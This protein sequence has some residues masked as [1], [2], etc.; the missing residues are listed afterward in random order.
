MSVRFSD[1]ARLCEELRATNSK[2]EKS[3]LLADF[4]KGLDDA[5]LTQACLF[6][7]GKA[8]PETDPRTLKVST[9]TLRKVRG[10]A[11]RHG[12]ALTVADVAE[13]FQELATTTGKGSRKRVDEL[14]NELF[15]QADELERTYLLKII[16]GE[17]QIG[18][19]EGVLLQGIA[20]GAGV[21]LEE[22][23][24]A[25]MFLGHAGEVA[26]LALRA[27]V[28]GLKKVTL[29]VFRPVQPMLAALAE[30]FDTVLKEHGGKT[31]LEFKF[32]GARVQIHKRG[33]EVRVFSRHLSDVTGSLPDL[34]ERVRRHVQA[35]SVV[36]EGEVVAVS[37]DGRPLAFQELMRRFRRVHN[38]ETIQK[39]V[40]VRLY[41]FDLL[42]VNGQPQI[43]AP[44]QNRWLLLERCSPAEFLVQRRI[45][46]DAEQAQAF[47]KQALDLGHEGLMAKRLDSDYAP[48]ARGKKWFKIKPSETLD[49]VVVAADWG[50]GR[51][52]G[53]LSNYHLAV[54][55]KD[56]GGFLEV[57]KTFKGLT[58]QQ[59]R[60]MTQK[61]QNLKTRER[62]PTV[63]VRPDIV[64]EV[65]YNEIQRS[66]HY[67]SGFALRFARIKRI[68]EDKS[69]QQADT[70]GRLRKLYEK[71]FERK[72]RSA[73]HR[74]FK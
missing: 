69:P 52:Q 70:I 1:F 23:R 22:V 27:G 74:R 58:D 55:D 24:R 39:E 20:E 68:R 21:A 47:L 65:A 18:V 53:W 32:D 35:E 12:S 14:L 38:I 3:R 9:A 7:L 10:E 6:L 19:A 73:E 50:S 45:T 59:F 33:E 56:T 25:N 40:P 36:L 42:Y 30:D 17:M 62:G 34:V 8:F 2:L 61:L 67:P 41:L 46:D 72:G 31:A 37:R 16:F 57:G 13:C 64:V 51:R 44:Y 28:E 54:V 60:W 29:E 15:G 11:T 5:D 49:L 4:L 66:P 48:G 43:E 63:F 71:Q 26:R